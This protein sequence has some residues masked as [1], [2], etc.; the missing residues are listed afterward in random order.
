MDD[1]VTYALLASSAFFV[2][3]AFGL[4]VRYRQASQKIVASTDMGRDL[5][6]ALEQRLRKQDERILD[7]M[8]RMEVIQSRA[9]D[10][11]ASPAPMVAPAPIPIE[12]RIIPS[13]Q[14][15]A[16]VRRPV[17]VT[18][19]DATEMAVIRLLGD[20]SRSSVEIKQLIGKSREHTARL[21]KSLFDRNLVVRDDSNRPF[22]YELTDAGRR[23]LSA[24]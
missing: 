24:G 11:A 15:P 14:A 23:Y 1:L 6:Q 18:S 4:L 10:R 2:A 7:I 20:G 22:V 8:G 5:W 12:K 16:S 13:A 17:L 19:P 9:A 3:L 21:M